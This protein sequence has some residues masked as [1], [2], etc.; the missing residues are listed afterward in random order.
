VGVIADL[1][2]GDGGDEIPSKLRARAKAAIGTERSGSLMMEEA[3]DLGELS[4]TAEED[5]ALS[6]PEPSPSV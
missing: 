2:S 3:S 6:R 1:L 4:L 5:G